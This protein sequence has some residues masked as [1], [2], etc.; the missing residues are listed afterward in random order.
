MSEALEAALN[1]FP[2]DWGEP[3]KAFVERAVEFDGWE[4]LLYWSDSTI[5]VKLTADTLTGIYD[6]LDPDED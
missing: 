3:Y 6:I 5:R 2:G 1:L 4:I